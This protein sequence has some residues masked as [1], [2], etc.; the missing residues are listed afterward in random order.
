ML[1][2]TI[3]SI[4]DL[5]SIIDEKTTITNERLLWYRGQS[6]ASWGLTPTLLRQTFRC[7]EETLVARFKQNASML[8]DKKP[9]SYFDWLFLMQHYGV[10][11]RLLDWTESPLIALYFAIEKEDAADGALWLLEP[12]ELNKEARITKPTEPLFI[13]S[14]D[15]QL[16]QPYDGSTDSRTEVYPIATIATRNSVRIQAQQG[17]FTIHHPALNKPI[18]EIGNKKHFYKAVIPSES[19][20]VLKKQ[21]KLLGISKFQLFPEL[22]S[23]GELI[24][25]VM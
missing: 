18:E 21:L 14:F 25:E 5:L 19:K 12:L 16:L 8:I 6:D 4:P 10:P 11:T 7:S 22:A 13:P 20:A 3:N 1:E 2:M 24:K 9:N 15:D 23:V 17:V